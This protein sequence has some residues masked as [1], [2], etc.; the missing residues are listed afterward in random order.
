MKKL[1]FH[2]HFLFN[3]IIFILAVSAQAQTLYWQ[4]ITS[5]V[6]VYD[7]L[8]DGVENLYFS[9]GSGNTYFYRSTDLGI[10]WTQLGNGSLRLYRIA[11]DSN[12]VLWGGNDIEGG[13]YKSTNHGESWI[14]SLNSNDKITSITVSPNNWI[15]SGTYDGKVLF[16]SNEGNSWEAKNFTEQISTIT[17]NNNNFIFAGSSNGKIYRSTNLGGNWELMF[18]STGW[19]II[20]GI[21]VNDDNYIYANLYGQSKRIL[22]IDNGITWVEILGTNLSSLYINSYHQIFGSEWSYGGYRSLDSCLTWQYIGPAWPNDPN[23]FTFIDSLI[24]VG[25]QHGVF[26]YD[27]AFQ[28]Y[29]SNNYFPLNIGNIWQFNTR[30]SGGFAG[31]SMYYVEKDTIIQNNKYFILKGLVN[32][33]V[34]YDQ[35]EDCMYLRWNDSDYVLMDYSLNEGSTFQH[36]RFNSHQIE[37]VTVLKPYYLNIFDSLYHT[38]GSVWGDSGPPSQALY[39]RYSEMLGETTLDSYY[40]S[41]HG[42]SVHCTRK[43]IRAILVDSIATKYFSDFQSPE[44]NFSPIFVTSQFDFSLTLTVNHLYSGDTQYGHVNFIDSVVMFSKYSN[45]DSIIYNEKVIAENEPS[46]INYYISFPLDSTLMKNNF[47]FYYKF[48]AVDKGVVPEYSIMPDTGFY[49]LIY[50]SNYVSVKDYEANN[51]SNFSL[52]QNYPNPFNP[53]TRINY[54][55]KEEGLVEII[56]YDIL[57]NK[58]E[59][60]LQERKT[61]GKYSIDYDASRFSSG[62]YFYRLQVND[63]IDTKK[64]ILLK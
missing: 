39:T 55:I 44:I 2:F 40:S 47:K 21:V 31:N 58:L 53:I 56:L 48:Y 25:T 42:G 34:R 45:G 12:G 64:M 7:L 3:S 63:F 52:E 24:F 46:S 35:E 60:I 37:N 18:Q 11:I 19:S 62:I 32:D 57:G 30:C 15:W 13:I 33:I 17:S 28:P 41:P 16:S 59:I 1:R 51:I 10:T 14:N 9:G 54:S 26:K 27:P 6:P 49:E 23:S 20:K 4:S 8:Y 29:L 43:M 50:D 22:S 38:K 61:V 36:I 5:D